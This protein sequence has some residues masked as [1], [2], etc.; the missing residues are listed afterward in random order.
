MK[1]SIDGVTVGIKKALRGTR[2]KTL[3]ET[4]CAARHVAHVNWASTPELCLCDRDPLSVSEGGSR[5]GKR[6]SLIHASASPSDSPHEHGLQVRLRFG[7]RWRTENTDT[8]LLSLWSAY[9][10]D[11]SVPSCMWLCVFFIWTES[12]QASAEPIDLQLI[13]QCYECGCILSRLVSLLPVPWFPLPSSPCP[14]AF[15]NRPLR[16]R[17]LLSD[18]RSTPCSYIDADLF[19]TLLPCLIQTK[20]CVALLVG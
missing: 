6:K 1:P 16:A 18:G 20:C 5:I 2:S 4:T 3:C 12:M 17:V 19:Y 15:H 10:T 13:Y 7:R 8:L 14:L 9:S 11:G